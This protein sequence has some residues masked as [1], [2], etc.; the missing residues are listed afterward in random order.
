[1]GHAKLS[2]SSASRWINCPGS[3]QLTA[4]MPPQKPTIFTAEG[5][6]AHAFGEQM[7]KA[8]LSKEQLIAKVGD[9]VE[10]D[11]FEIEV[12]DD[13]VEAVF[14]YFDTVEEIIK[15]LRKLG[16]PGR[17]TMKVEEQVKVAGTNGEVYGTGDAL[18]FV[19]GATLY[20]IDY[21]HGKGVS[22]EVEKNK[23]MMIYGV[24][25]MDTIAG[26]AY[27][28]VILM[29]VQPRA[30]HKDGPV[31]TWRTNPAELYKFAEELKDAVA[32]TKVKHPNFA[33]GDHCR[34]CPGKAD[35]PAIFE[36][37]Q[38]KAQ[39]DFSVVP[40]K[41]TK[42]E[43]KAAM[44]SHVARISMVKAVEALK[45]EG[46]TKDLFAAIKEKVQLE[47]EAGRSVEGYKLVQ[48][49]TNRQWTDE[50]LVAQEFALTLTDDQMFTK[51][52]LSPAKLEK[53]V[54][55]GKVDHLTTKP[56]GPKAV[57]KES[58]PRPAVQCSA[59]ADFTAISHETDENVDN[60][61]YGTGMSKVIDMAIAKDK[62]EADLNDLL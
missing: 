44:R 52:I 47:L 10:E 61:V 57:A 48:G 6:V 32:A 22:V 54:G 21:K 4:D 56:K 9:I 29:I 27:D 62:I 43:N 23:Q 45:W 41:R 3:I 11:G 20:V 14:L 19:K 18:L 59:Q 30:P 46:M 1:M 39:A 37:V 5:T 15:G 16:K 25:A 58:D 7:L 13:M 49:K 36:A 42:D 2:P 53:I 17:V 55:K 51:K 34:W 35:C 38:E 24:G 31:R 28:E 8:K 50:S 33:A 12:T 40:A 26:K 60:E